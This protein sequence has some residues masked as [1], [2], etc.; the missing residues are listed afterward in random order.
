M[1]PCVVSP[2]RLNLFSF[3]F[4]SG[5][6]SPPICASRPLVLRQYAVDEINTILWAALIT[7]TGLLLRRVGRLIRFW[8]RGSRLPGPPCPAFVGHSSSI[9]KAGGIDNFTAFLSQSHR[10]Y[11]SVVRVWLGPTQ[12]LVSVKDPEIIREVLVQA[13]DRLPLTG[14]TFQLAFGKSS[15]FVSSFAQVQKR[16][17]SLEQQLNGKTLERV[18]AI[19]LKVV[20]LMLESVNVGASGWELDCKSVSQHMA[21]SVLGATLFGDG[22][23]VWS[24]AREYEELLMM[25]AKEACFWATYSVLPFWNK[26]FQRYRA[27]CARLQKLTEQMMEKGMKQ[28]CNM[29]SSQHAS[30]TETSDAG[31]AADYEGTSTEFSE[32]LISGILFSQELSGHLNSVKEPPGNIMG[33]MF[34]GCLTTAGIMSGVLTNLAHHPEIQAKVYGEIV[35]ICGKSVQP[36]LSDVQQMHFLLAT[37]HESTRLLPAGR[38]LQRCSLKHDLKLRNDLTVPAGAI[39]A[40]PIQLVQTDAF[41]WGSD[42]SIFKPERFF[43]QKT[44]C[45]NLAK[46]ETS[47]EKMSRRGA[48]QIKNAKVE[49]ARVIFEDFDSNS[50]FLP[51]GLGSRVCVGKRFAIVE[52]T[53]LLASLLQRYEIKLG[54][55]SDKDFKQKIENCVL[56]LFPNPKLI[57]VPRDY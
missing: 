33:M 2:S 10:E 40:V 32:D 4:R 37:L 9:V 13:E 38:L 41:Y 20:D 52:M 44:V 27:M 11:G 14:K 17:S 3:L 21:F 16:R 6:V 54:P 5:I 22:F 1:S 24:A 26:R 30:H 29:D 57:L 25:I 42:A 43:E 47:V 50:S 55:G 8:V 18:H 36:R 19:S 12:L 45:I 39:L 15:L 28:H 35:A 49:D 53:T 46:I 7:V 23:L 56:E 31:M 34:H 51:F 48:T